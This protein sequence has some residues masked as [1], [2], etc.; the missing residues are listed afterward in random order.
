MNKLTTSLLAIAIL[1]YCAFNASSLVK[2]SGSLF[3]AYSRY[4]L[5]IWT[6]PFLFS[7]LK[8]GIALNLLFLGIALALSFFSVIAELNVFAHLALVFAAAGLMPWNKW[9]IPW[10]VAAMVWM[11][12]FSYFAGH[13]IP[14]LVLPLRLAM[15]LIGVASGIWANIQRKQA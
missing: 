13:Y 9:L 5:A 11:P 7:I 2:P 4:A 8:N 15:T 10:M 3:E 12:A 1:G 14:T 6:L